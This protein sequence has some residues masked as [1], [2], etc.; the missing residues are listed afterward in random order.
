MYRP[1]P[2]SAG[3]GLLCLQFYVALPVLLLAPIC[4]LLLLPHKTN[5]LL[6]LLGTEIVSHSSKSR[7]LL[8]SKD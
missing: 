5:D 1:P 4:R 6:H 3:G 2:T 7:I 8:L